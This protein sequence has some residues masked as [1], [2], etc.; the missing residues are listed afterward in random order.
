M[1]AANYTADEA[2]GHKHLLDGRLAAN[3]I[4]SMATINVFAKPERCDGF[5]G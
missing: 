5:S 3:R 2:A 1:G 4:S